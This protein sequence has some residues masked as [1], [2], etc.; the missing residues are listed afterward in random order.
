MNQKCTAKPYYFLFIDTTLISD[1]SSCFREN[2]F[3]ENIK[4]DLDN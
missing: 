2:F 4:T 3:R 1:N